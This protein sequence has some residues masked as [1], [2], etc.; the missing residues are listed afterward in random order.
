MFEEL[1]E[2]L[3]YEDDEGLELSCSLSF[4]REV[5][6]PSSSQPV[7]SVKWDSG[8]PRPILDHHLND[9]VVSL[10]LHGKAKILFAE[11]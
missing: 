2:S 1:Q 6:R 7:A 3:R 10:L 5:R 8:N 11:V 9:K 4:S